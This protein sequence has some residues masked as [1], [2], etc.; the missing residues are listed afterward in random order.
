[1]FLSY[2]KH[3]A[4]PAA[5]GAQVLDLNLSTM[6]LNNAADNG[7]PKPCALAHLLGGEKRIKNMRQHIHRDPRSPVFHQQDETRGFSFGKV[8]QS[9]NLNLTPFAPFA[10][11][12]DCIA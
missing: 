2:G 5:T 12:G 3:N 9:L 8:E 1:L 11:G 6:P 10:L 4:K 7:K